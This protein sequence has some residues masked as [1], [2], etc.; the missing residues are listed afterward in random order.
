MPKGIRNRRFKAVKSVLYLRLKNGAIGLHKSDS[1]FSRAGAKL[2][3]PKRFSSST[4]HSQLEH[5]FRNV[6]GF[7]FFI[8]DKIRAFKKSLFVTPNSDAERC[9]KLPTQKVLTFYTEFRCPTVSEI[10]RF[11]V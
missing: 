3:I 4:A 8:E 2:F 10:R 9:P 11:K 7:I 1:G 6:R 5:R